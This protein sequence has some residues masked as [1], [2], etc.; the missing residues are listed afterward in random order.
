MLY[1]GKEIA[2]KYSTETIRITENNIRNWTRKG[3]K[4]VSGPHN[5]FL[6]K[7][8]WVEEYLENQALENVNKTEIYDFEI[9][10]KNEKRKKLKK[11]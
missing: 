5:Q 2:K 9:K 3:L 6:Y 10:H 8:E 4:H 1:T 7:E 11:I